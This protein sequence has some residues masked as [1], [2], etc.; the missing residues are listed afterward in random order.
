MNADEK[1]LLIERALRV[2][3][4]YPILKT[5]KPDE[6][7][8]Y[9]KGFFKM[10]NAAKTTITPTVVD[11]HTK[12]IEV[13]IGPFAVFWFRV[14]E[15]PS[16]NNPIRVSER[17]HELGKIRITKHSIECEGET[18]EGDFKSVFKVLN[19]LAVY[20]QKEREIKALE[21]VSEAIKE[22]LNTY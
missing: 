22:H 15:T 14:P 10:I 13:S 11:I 17:N 12:D 4:E 16:F 19:K 2:S 18:I 7:D 1:Q 20:N 6:V 21:S 8:T 3:D 9:E 5:W